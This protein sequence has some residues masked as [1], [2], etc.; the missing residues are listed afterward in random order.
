M[1][2]LSFILHGKHRS[3]T[4]LVDEARRIFG[5]THTV[6]FY[7]T[8]HAGHAINLAKQAAL[9]GSYVIAAGGDGTMNEVINGIML[10]NNEQVICGLLPCGTGNDFAKTIGV[11]NNLAE[12]KQLINNNQVTAIDVGHIKLKD[13]TGADVARYFINIAD[14]GLG[15]II[16]Q[17]LA[18]YNK[19]MGAFITFQR[20][21]ISGFLSFKHQPVQAKADTFLYNGKILSYIIA[22]GKYF[23]AGLGIAPHANPT[24]GQFAIVLGAEISLWDYLLNLGKVRQCKPIV[25]PQMSYHSAATVQID[26]AQKLPIDMDGEFAGYTPMQVTMLPG[27]IRL[28]CNNP[29]PNNIKD[30]VY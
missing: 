19:W 16:A 23:G 2:T 11:K 13:G 20:A 5:D 10:S 22:N 30:K 4:K 25:H 14:V 24:D 27:A 26:S 28:L 6:A 17:K 9:Q 12:L 15:G 8:E 29:A 21:I 3:N 1:P 7:Y 18:G